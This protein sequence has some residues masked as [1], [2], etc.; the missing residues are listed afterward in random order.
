MFGK[1]FEL[2]EETIPVVEEIG[3][4]MPGG[5]FIYRADTD[6]F[7]SKSDRHFFSHPNQGTVPRFASATFLQ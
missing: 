7:I 3:R 6:V 1:R 5:F 2:N 4:H